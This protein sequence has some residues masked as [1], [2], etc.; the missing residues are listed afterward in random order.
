[1]G[2][3]A[4]RDQAICLMVMTR[5]IMLSVPR[6]NWK[7]GVLETPCRREKISRV[8]VKVRLGLILL[9]SLRVAQMTGNPKM[10]VSLLHMTPGCPARGLT[11]KLENAISLSVAEYA[12]QKVRRQ[13]R[14]C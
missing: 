2:F 4:I 10:H 8:V 11:G 13:I 1:M 12:K 5:M 6:Y 9:P 14:L 7:K 3:F